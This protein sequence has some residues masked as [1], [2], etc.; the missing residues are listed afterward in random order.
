MRLPFVDLAANRAWLAEVCFAHDLVRWFQRLC[1]TGDLASAEPKTL[2]WRL[3]HVP[4][5]KI[6]SGRRIIVRILEDW[7]DASAIVRAHR[8]IALLA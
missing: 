8:R 5:R 4:A 7:P 2:R 1:L 6:R 3:W